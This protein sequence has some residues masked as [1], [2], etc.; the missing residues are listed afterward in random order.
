[1]TTPATGTPPATGRP[2]PILLY[3]S[4]SA[5][6]TAG[7][8]P[9]AVDPGRFRAH[10]ELVAHAGYRTLTVRELGAILAD[11]SGRVP[12]RTAVITF[13]DGFDDVHREA[14]PVL[15]QLGLTA[16]A[17]LVTG[18]LG[19]TSRWLAATGEG[20]R[21]LLSWTQVRELAAAGIEIGSHSH[22]HPELDTLPADLAGEELRRSRALLEDGLGAAVTSFAYPYGYHTSEL[23]GLLRQNGYEAGCAVKHALSHERDDRWALGRAVVSADTSDEQLTAWLD[24]RGLP[25]AWTGERPQTIGW[26]AVRRARSGFARF[27]RPHGA[28]PRA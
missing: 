1:M 13:D 10:M 7:Y 17:F 27:R 16:T 18:F 9:F 21:R 6:A 25:V 28:A 12:E 22:S 19:G 3:H 15:E 20:D 4:I 23:K 2:I 14:L 8:R 5:E 24:G 11:P 26:R